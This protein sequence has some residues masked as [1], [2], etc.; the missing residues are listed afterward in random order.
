[1]LIVNIYNLNT[2]ISAL[3]KLVEFIYD[4]YSG[5]DAVARFTHFNKLYVNIYSSTVV[6]S[7]MFDHGDRSN[8]RICFTY[9]AICAYRERRYY[10]NMSV[11]DEYID[12]SMDWTKAGRDVRY[13]NE[14][15]MMSVVTWAHALWYFCLG[16]LRLRWN[17]YFEGDNYHYGELK[18][19]SKEPALYCI[20]TGYGLHD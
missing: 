5:I 20:W 13:S 3:T 7:E 18:S 10:N 12:I 11:Q 4:I 14:C 19:T 8:N 16:N 17:L 15:N 1:M 6:Y 2:T 9:M